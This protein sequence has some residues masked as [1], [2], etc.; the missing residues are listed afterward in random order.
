MRLVVNS[1]IV[2]VRS[3]KM[4][5]NETKTPVL[6]RRHVREYILY[7][8]LAAVAYLIPTMYLL[9]ENKYQ[10]LYLLFVGN[11]LFMAV[12]FYYNYRLIYHPYDGKRAVSMLMAGH[13][14]TW[15]GTILAAVI[16]TVVMF[17]FF[18]DLFSRHPTSEVLEQA[19]VSA[20]TPYPSGFLFMVLL[21][22]ILGNASVG[23]FVSILASYVN[24]RNQTKDQ[25]ADVENRIPVQSHNK[26]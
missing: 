15:I 2:G 1:T 13:L 24:K 7:G 3:K 17:M 20:R 10:N 14:A 16:V 18:P 9:F 8:I 11:A 21:D 23:S 12:I 6:D 25:P 5:M 19:N 22:V 26:A 4:G